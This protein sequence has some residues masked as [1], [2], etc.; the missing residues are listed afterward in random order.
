MLTHSI[1]LAG[2]AGPPPLVPY[3]PTHPTSAPPHAGSPGQDQHHSQVTPTLGSEGD[4]HPHRAPPVTAVGPFSWLCGERAPTSGAPAAVAARLT[5]DGQAHCP[6]CPP[7]SLRQSRLGSQQCGEQTLLSL[8]TAGRAGHCL[9]LGWR[10]RRP[11]H[12]RKMPAAHT[13]KPP[14][15]LILVATGVCAQG[16]HRTSST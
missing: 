7:G 13:G 4:N 12:N 5:A 3:R 8:P 11:S 16:H 6:T 2:R 1:H 9:R 14:E 15:H 10:R